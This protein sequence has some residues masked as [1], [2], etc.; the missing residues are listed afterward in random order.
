MIKIII[1][2][3]GDTMKRLYIVI[4]YLFILMGC[5][6]KDNIQI[7]IIE[8]VTYVY[9]INYKDD[10]I[11]KVVIDY[12]IKDYNDIFNIYTIYQNRL[13]LGYYVNANSNVTLLKSYV[14]DNNIYYVVDKYINLTEDIGLFIKILSLSNE[15][16]GYNKTFIICNN[17]TFGI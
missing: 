15:L 10:K 14:N 4:F 6:K 12:E 16:L 11:E 8:D 7:D 3:F 17:K 2:F 5:S 9:A 13:P 1:K